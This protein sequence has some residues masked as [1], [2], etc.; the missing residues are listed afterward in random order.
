MCVDT[1]PLQ[2]KADAKLCIPK[3]MIQFKASYTQQKFSSRNYRLKLPRAAIRFLI[4]QN[5]PSL[6]TA[7]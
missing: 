3:I 2:R 4:F 7:P 6:H 1:Y 5:P